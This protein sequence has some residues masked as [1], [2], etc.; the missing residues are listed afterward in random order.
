[1]KV[2]KYEDRIAICKTCPFY[3]SSI[4]ACRACGCSLMVKA[5]LKWFTCK[6]G[7]WTKPDPS[8]DSQQT[9]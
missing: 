6:K 5:R 7:K 8:V 9:P 1:M 2:T 3:I 4:A